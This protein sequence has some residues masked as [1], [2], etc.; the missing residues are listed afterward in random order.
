LII[1]VAIHKYYTNQI[2]IIDKQR[3]SQRWM[4]WL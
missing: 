4:F 3:K 1:I 2:N